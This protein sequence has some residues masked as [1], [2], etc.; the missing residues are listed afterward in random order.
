MT[1]IVEAASLSLAV[2]PIVISVAEHYSSAARALNRYR[3][4]SSEI[5]RLLIFVKI[6]R[7][8]YYCEIQ[9]L[10]SHCV[11][12]ERAE[13]LLGDT[14]NAQWKDGGLEALFATKL[15]SYREPFMEL[16]EHINVELSEMEANLGTFEE[17]A[18]LKDKVG[19]VSFAC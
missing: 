1:G 5:R 19:A 6:Q 3:Q 2:I 16:V 11:G 14:D 17:V 9:S 4:F 10:L 8:R 18:Q 13:L 12:L 15:G 7:T